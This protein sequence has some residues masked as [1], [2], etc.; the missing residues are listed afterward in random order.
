[1]LGLRQAGATKSRTERLAEQKAKLAAG[2]QPEFILCQDCGKEKPF[3][4]WPKNKRNG[5]PIGH[6]S[7]CYEK[8]VERINAYKATNNGKQILKEAKARYEKTSKGK[9]TKRRYLDTDKGKAK[10]KR[11]KSSELGKA[12]EKRFRESEHGQASRKRALENL[13]ARARLSRG[14]NLN[15]RLKA[16]AA[17]LLSGRHDN[18]P[19]FL[20]HTS[21]RSEQQFIDAVMATLKGRMTKE[22]YGKE[23]ELDHKIPREAYNFNNPDDV[24]RC[25][26]PA[27]VTALTK[28]ENG[29]KSW[30][31]I[32]SWIHSA[33]PACFPLAWQNRMPT[34]EMRKA[35]NDRMK[36]TKSVGEQVE[37]PASDESEDES[38]ED[39]FE[40][41]GDRGAGSSAEHAAY[42]LTEEED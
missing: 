30:K 18:S 10:Q 34:D 29:E 15:L 3:F 6:C 36:A 19:T 17:H 1:M 33:G 25:W 22:N 9:A 38:E 42:E 32:D 4:E 21:F 24:L 12:V 16:I 39:E 7:L 28:L 35:H 37:A 20:K 26:S 23:W 8:R 13:K 2:E 31:L 5:K 41:C 40:A 27:N 14:M 11:Y